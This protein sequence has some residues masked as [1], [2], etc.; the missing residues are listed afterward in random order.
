MILIITEN[1]K[2]Q[3]QEHSSVEGFRLQTPK[4]WLRIQRA[5]AFANYT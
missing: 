2:S 1:K 4:Q 5:L 3:E